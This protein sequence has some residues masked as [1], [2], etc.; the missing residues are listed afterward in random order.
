[1][2]AIGSGRL[3]SMKNKTLVKSA[4]FAAISISLAGIAM[5]TVSWFTNLVVIDNTHESN[6][7]L[8]GETLGAYFAYGNGIPSSEGEGN[9][10]YGI[11]KPRHLYNLAWLQYLGFLDN[12]NLNPGDS[13]YA[14]QYYFELAEDLD[15]TGW[16]LP[17]I[18]TEEHPFIGNFAGNGH[19]ISNLT[20]SNV[21]GDYN[22]HPSAV[23]AGDFVSPDIVGLFGVV[24]NYTGYGTYTSSVNTID[25]FGLKDLTVTSNSATTLV[26]LVAGYVDAEIT[27]VAI[28]NPTLQI[29]NQ[30]ATK[31]DS[32]LTN[33]ISD[34]MVI[35]YCKDT[36]SK[37]YT[38]DVS[39]VTDTV[40]DVNV[41]QSSPFTITE[42]GSNT[43]WGGSI[44][45]LEMYTK[46]DTD[47][48]KLRHGYGN[49]QSIDPLSYDSA[50][51]DTYDF[52]GNLTSSNIT[53]TTQNNMPYGD[54]GQISGSGDNHKYY[55]V[56]KNSTLTNE[57]TNGTESLQTSSVS[58]V[59]QT[60]GTNQ[61][62]EE[63]FMCLTGKKD[64]SITDGLTV[65]TNHY[66][67]QSGKYI[68]SGTHYL[69]VDNNAIVNNSTSQTTCWVFDGGKLYTANSSNQ[70]LYLVC[71]NNGTLSLNT[72]VNNATSWTYDSSS[73]SIFAIVNNNTYLLVYDNNAWKGQTYTIDHYLIH[74][75][76]GHYLR[77]NGSANVTINGSTTY[78]VTNPTKT[79]TNLWWYKN[80]DYFRTTN[81]NGYYLLR[82]NTT[83]LRVR[84]STTNR[85]TYD[86][87]YFSNGGYYIYNNG[88][89]FSLSNTTA[90]RTVM[91]LEPVYTT[92]PPAINYTG[93]GSIKVYSSD[94]T[95]ED[96]T[97]S[98]PHTYFPLRYNDSNGPD[99]K[100]TGYVVSGGNYYDDPYGD[101]R[102]SSYAISTYLNGVSTTNSS[103]SAGQYKSI[104]TVYTKQFNTS[105]GALNNTD[106]NA[107]TVY[108]NSERYAT[109]KSAMEHVFGGQTNAYGLH[110]MKATINGSDPAVVPGAV[111]NGSIYKNLEL[112]TDC[113][114]FHLKE[115][116]VINFFAGIYYTNN[117]SFFS[118]YE[119]DRS[120]A[121]SKATVS[122]TSNEITLTYQGVDTNKHM[123]FSYSSD[124]FNVAGHTY[125]HVSINGN[126]VNEEGEAFDIT[127]YPGDGSNYF[128]LDKGSKKYEYFNL[129]FYDDQG[130]AYLDFEATSQRTKLNEI[131][132]ITRVWSNPNDT[133][134][135]D[136]YCY[137]YDINGNTR[138][139]VPYTYVM[140]RKVDLDGSTPYVE[141]RVT[142]TKPSGYTNMA[143]STTCIEVGPSNGSLASTTSNNT[144]KG[145]VYYFEVPMN[146][147]EFALGSVDGYNGA[148]LMYLDIAA[149]AS[150]IKRTTMTEHFTS[151][152]K[153]FKYPNTIAIVENVATALAAIT[154]D[155]D[156]DSSE[157]LYVTLDDSFRGE[158]NVDVAVI[159]TVKTATLTRTNLANAPNDY[160]AGNHAS[161]G[162]VSDDITL[163]RGSG[164]AGPLTE[165]AIT[166]T[167]TDYK[168]VNYYDFSVT[169]GTTWTCI[170]EATVN[171]VAQ[172][173]TVE[174]TENDTPVDEAKIKIYGEDGRSVTKANVNFNALTFKDTPLVV[175]F[176]FMT[177]DAEQVS[178]ALTLDTS[179]TGENYYQFDSYT[180]VVANDGNTITIK[181]IDVG[182]IPVTINGNDPTSVTSFQAP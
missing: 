86:G 94:Q 54:Y 80:G 19:I 154:E 146:E 175:E 11:T 65:T 60:A 7:Q 114:D 24:G 121:T 115:K 147:G 84:N 26:G 108:A 50:R 10:V 83:S 144:T 18:G 169:N 51:T 43:G 113:I 136:S 16:V 2:F 164:D 69:T 162:Y 8:S 95:T 36:E 70:K 170:T 161:P 167:T 130:V 152:E 120:A 15:M 47:W 92:T 127:N 45:M 28:Q 106:A 3:A 157:S 141:G 68:S 22:T 182:T 125:H 112:P 143:F 91:Y 12:T 110:F 76:A 155:D 31:L 89:S 137:Q 42:Q 124:P 140:G 148:Y 105:T 41:T 66:P 132:R 75:D 116:G 77:H 20:V 166:T 72:N 118:L 81:S 107:N 87:T 111:I 159:S 46:L 73:N 9:R 33:N 27:N 158:I 135:K 1:M 151:V 165:T 181:V 58:Y 64:I 171:G 102:V 149:N 13:G 40:Y 79:N 63:R 25:T 6:T 163:A 82:Y 97:L 62:T 37:R 139:S 71:A 153:T 119:I 180:I 14:T 98:I 129:K 56:S 160:V 174:Q 85:L 4:F 34:Y 126:T 122:G 103:D 23:T 117:K 55:N 131:R 150:L 179:I 177:D 156:I 38:T 39:K 104:N 48:K 59:V 17:P 21:F 176:Y 142:T 123:K 138:Y 52:D 134:G 35:G 61:S 100:N 109:S 96:A 168:R 67:T 145:Y 44:D 101:I 93:N 90:N 178:V 57:D 88:S 133:D 49:T 172:E 32:T 128:T 99:E 5:S 173:R 29:S 74:D 53:A 30:N 78:C